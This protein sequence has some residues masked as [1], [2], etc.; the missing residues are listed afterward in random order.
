MSLPLHERAQDGSSDAL[1]RLT[2][3]DFL[4]PLAAAPATCLRLLLCSFLTGHWGQESNTAS[5]ST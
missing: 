5:T 3:E 4:K 1:V 2:L